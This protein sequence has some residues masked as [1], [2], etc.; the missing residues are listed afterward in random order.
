MNPFLSQLKP[1]LRWIPSLLGVLLFF[2][3]LWVIHQELQ[4]YSLADI[5]QNLAATPRQA[6]L[7]ALGLTLMNQGVFTGY[8]T[9]AARYVHQP[10]P[11][12]QTAFAAITS[13][14]VGNSVGLGLLSNGAVRYR[15]YSAW[16]VPAAAIAHIVAF[17]N[18]SFWLG[19]FT[20]GGVLFLAQP[21][22]LP[23]QLHLPFHS[24]QSIG[25]IGLSITLLYFGWN[26]C[27]QKSLRIGGFTFPHLPTQL[28]IAQ[29]L[30]ASLDWLLAAAVLYAL[31]PTAALS[32]PA[33]LGVYLLAQIAGMI[34]NVPG[35]LGVFETVML[36]LVSP[37]VA[38]AVLLGILLV[39]RVIYYLLP[40]TIAVVLLGSYELRQKLAGH[41]RNPR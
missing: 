18:L 38:P 25:W 24:V 32:Y 23:L 34:S 39:Y 35:G 8:D 9:L 22:A 13:T 41:S 1:L 33:F 21:I 19:L 37:P 5:L 20:V 7:L 6:L 29:I 26:L 4:Q 15:L 17:C 30:V 36:L 3:S 14:A 12:R 31:L 2:A 28:C 27:S 11:Y 10:L 16:G 40:L